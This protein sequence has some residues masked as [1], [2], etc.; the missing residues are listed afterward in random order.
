MDGRQPDRGGI[1]AGPIRPCWRCGYGARRAGL[2]TATTPCRPAAPAARDRA[3]A[4]RRPGRPG[5]RSYLDVATEIQPL[6]PSRH[7]RWRAC[8]RR[9]SARLRQPRRLGTPAGVRPRPGGVDQGE[10]GGPRAAGA[11]AGRAAAAAET[12]G[13]EVLDQTQ[14]P[15]AEPGQP[16]GASRTTTIAGGKI[17]IFT[18]D[19]LSLVQTLAH[20]LKVLAW[21]LLFV[22]GPLRP[23]RC[24]GLPAH[25]RWAVATAGS[26]SSW[27][28]SSS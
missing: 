6:L 28:V 21:V 27:P 17:V 8:V 10:P 23:C 2:G 24:L 5:L 11:G 16:P 13:G 26:A 19:Q 4:G 22:A 15:R 7:S 1:A 25:R 9:R 20:W 3:G 12:A 14:R 18:S